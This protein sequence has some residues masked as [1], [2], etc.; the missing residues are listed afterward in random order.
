MDECVKYEGPYKNVLSDIDKYHDGLLFARSKSL[1]ILTDFSEK[2]SPS[3][4][5]NAID[6]ATT[7]NSV[8][9]AIKTISSSHKGL[10][11]HVSKVGKSIEKLND[12]RVD[13]ILP[14][15]GTRN[16]LKKAVAMHFAIEEIRFKQDDNEWGAN[17]IGEENLRKID[18]MNEVK[19]VLSDL[20]EKL[21][22]SSLQKWI[23][24]VD[25]CELKFWYKKTCA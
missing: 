3:L 18:K 2:L 19:K 14:F 24:E 12:M 13:Q 10:H 21:E 23:S 11:M 5:G 1:Q 16:K 22:I 7:K 15:Q 8:K 4:S 6:S 17:I 9:T 20:T 25:S